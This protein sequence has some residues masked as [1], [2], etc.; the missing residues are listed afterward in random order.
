MEYMK[1]LD[2][3]TGI[4]NEA[5]FNDHYDEYVRKYK[6]ARLIMIDFEK[7]KSINDTFGHNVGDKYLTLFARLLNDNF[8]N[9]IVSRLHG[10]EYCVL[11]YF[12][13]DDIINVFKI[14]DDEIKKAVKKR[15]IPRE[16]SY[17]AG[18][19]FASTD[20]HETKEQADAMMYAGKQVGQR[21]KSFSFDIWLQKQDQKE[22]LEKIDSSLQE[23]AFSYSGHYLHTPDTEQTNIFHISTKDSAGHS[24]FFDGNYDV[25]RNDSKIIEFDKTNC[26]TLLPI[27]VTMDGRYL[28]GIDNKT[29][30][31]SD[32]LLKY[33]EYI[34]VSLQLDYTNI[35]F[36]INLIGLDQS[37]YQDFISRLKFLQELGFRICLDKYS[38]T[39]GD[40]LFESID[41]DYIRFDDKYWK[42]ALEDKK[43]ENVIRHKVD[44]FT[45]VADTTSIF[46]LVETKDEQSFI[47]TLSPT[48]LV[49]GNSYSKEKQLVLK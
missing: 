7:F 32:Y 38:S 31:S 46:G 20:L 22:F 8:P 5:Y 12:S 17:N 34:K 24:L 45:S 23:K 29:I 36:A 11:T 40:V 1:Y 6:N 13:D 41:A 30:L 42:K 44:M 48:I 3:L 18:S 37:K 21:Y 9:A 49:S 2:K 43:T 26:R 35:I 16:F 25:L 33:L 10:D 27:L 4:H 14:I 39:I 28:L 47:E 15:Q 19:T